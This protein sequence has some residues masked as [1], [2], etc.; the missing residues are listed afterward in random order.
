ME[1]TER[2]GLL[3]QVGVRMNSPTFFGNMLITSVLSELACANEGKNTRHRQRG[4]CQSVYRF[5]A[6]LSNFLFLSL[7][8]S[9]SAGCSG[10]RRA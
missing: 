7:L 10:E 5:I 3:Y 8:V 6:R 1:P 2:T 4:R 9:I